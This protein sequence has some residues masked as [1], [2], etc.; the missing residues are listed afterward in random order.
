MGLG[1]EG[2]RCRVKQG[3][4]DKGKSSQPKT[5]VRSAGVVRDRVAREPSCQAP[6]SPGV[7]CPEDLGNWWDGEG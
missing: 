4:G 2:H 1:G 3:K 7:L 6:A 5:R